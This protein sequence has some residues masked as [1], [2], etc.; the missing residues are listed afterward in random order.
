MAGMSVVIFFPTKASKTA[1]Y[2]LLRQLS[3]EDF[4]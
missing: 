3:F 1:S 2:L 4:L